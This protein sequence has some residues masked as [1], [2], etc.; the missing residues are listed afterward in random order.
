[1]PMLAK[2]NVNTEQRTAVQ[3]PGRT[4][5]HKAARSYRRTNACTRLKRRARVNGS[6]ANFIDD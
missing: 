3:V 1:M 4:A 6:V 2:L 5:T